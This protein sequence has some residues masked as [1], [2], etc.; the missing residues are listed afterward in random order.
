MDGD[1][2][3]NVTQLRIMMAKLLLKIQNGADGT[4]EEIA[5]WFARWH[6]SLLIYEL[7]D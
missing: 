4:D 1:L 5:K 7:E 6:E 3:T 2:S